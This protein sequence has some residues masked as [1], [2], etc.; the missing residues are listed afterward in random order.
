MLNS[1]TF[2]LIALLKYIYNY[3]QEFE[4]NICWFFGKEWVILVFRLI[5]SPYKDGVCG[6]RY[7]GEATICKQT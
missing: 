3:D 5:L 7:H 2:F 1:L 4:L 6:N